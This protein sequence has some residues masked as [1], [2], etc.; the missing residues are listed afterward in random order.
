LYICQTSATHLCKQARKTRD[1][2]QQK[3]NFTTVLVSLFVVLGTILAI[4]GVYGVVS[5]LVAQRTHELGDRV[6]ALSIRL[7]LVLAHRTAA[8]LDTFGVVNQPVENAISQRGIADL[9]MPARNG[10]LRSQNR[11][12]HLLQG[13]RFEC[14]PYEREVR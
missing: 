7:S 11:R 9:L 6:S 2:I 4:V 5:Y 14:K 1:S 12:T 8:H 13:S 10:Q 3:S